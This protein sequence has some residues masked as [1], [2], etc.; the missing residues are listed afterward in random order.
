LWLLAIVPF[1][2]NRWRITPTHL[3][4]K[5]YSKYLF[6][7]VCVGDLEGP[8][9]P[10]LLILSTNLSLPGLA[11]FSHDHL[12]NVPFD[13]SKITLIETSLN[14]LAQVVAASSAYPAFFPPISIKDRDIGAQEGSMGK[15]QYFTDAGIFDNLG[16]YGLKHGAPDPLDRMYASD[17]GRSFVPQKE[18]EFGIL[19]TALRAVDIFMF[20]IRELDLAEAS[21]V[22]SAL[23]ISI[24]DNINIPG[25]SSK[26]VQSQLENIRTDLDKF[27]EV[28]IEE[29]IRQG[30]YL[31]AKA[32]ASERGDSM[33]AA[34]PEWDIPT[35][36][37]MPS[38]SERARQLQNS[39][40]IRWHLFSARDWVSWAQAAMTALVFIALA[41]LRGPIIERV[42]IVVAG[43]HA[44]SLKNISLPE[45][46]DSPV[47]I[48]DV[49]EITPPVNRGFDIISDD[50]VW[51]LR[52]LHTSDVAGGRVQVV[53][54]AIMT[55]ISTLIRRDPNA[56]QYSYLFLTSAKQSF[57]RSSSPASDGV[58]L[59]RS[60][61]LAVSGRNVLTKYELQFDVSHVE[62]NREFILEGQMKTI[63]APWDRNN[64]WLAM[65]FT[66]PT[67]AASIRIIFPASYHTN[68]QGS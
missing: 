57:A 27:S 62:L 37:I 24:S 40:I 68:F 55:R 38:Q 7:D 58:K 17:A 54:T 63:D 13:Q 50:R 30:Y 36:T 66:D 4:A 15:G 3:L 49:K 14:P 48:E 20:R 64:T 51:D 67:P 61:T 33:P 34:I 45:W 31:T 22:Q 18:T 32:L 8:G 29:L 43:M 35:K 28:E 41:E 2:P 6:H 39:S 44:Y 53:G 19:R 42:N 47:A 16:L 25:A 11:C 10:A 23:L 60:E 56:N 65:R 21:R 52:G 46:K 1:I 26:P 59:L 9:G 5:Y 12:L